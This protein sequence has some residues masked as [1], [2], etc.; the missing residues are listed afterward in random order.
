M[1][2]LWRIALLRT[3]SIGMI[4]PQIGV[5]GSAIFVPSIASLLPEATCLHLVTVGFALLSVVYGVVGSQWS[6]WVMRAQSKMW[7]LEELKED[8]PANWLEFERNAR[9]AVIQWKD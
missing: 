5:M 6:T 4:L 2:F 9:W 7:I 8:H 1:F 3:L